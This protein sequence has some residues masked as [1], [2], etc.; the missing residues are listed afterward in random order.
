MKKSIFKKA[1]SLAAA[2]AMTLGFSAAIPAGAE[3]L[4]EAQQFTREMGAGWVLGN[5]LDATA[6]GSSL[7]SETSWGNP[8][9]TKAMIEAVHDAGFETIRIPVSWG[10]HTTG[11]NFEI[12]AEWL[13][14]VKQVVDWAYNDGM[15]VILNIHH[16]NSSAT[17]SRLYYYPDSA[18]KDASLT[19]LTSVWSQ[20][21]EEFQDYDDRLIFET[22]N[23]PRLCGTDYEWWFDP[24]N[25][26]DTVKDSLETINTF[27][28]EIVNT[29]REA[30][31]KN[32]ERYIMCPGYAASLSGITTSYF[33]V[34]EDP[35][36]KVLIAV[37]S[38]APQS[39]C[40]G[41]STDVTS[42]KATLFTDEGREE[43]TSLFETLNN[44]Y[45]SK[46]YG[47]VIGEMGI[48]NKDNNCART[49]WADH[50]FTKSKEYGIPCM[51]WD[52]NAKNGSNKSEN[53]WHF[54]RKTCKWGDP[55]VINA[56][57]DA[58]GVTERS[59]PADDD[60]VVKKPQTITG[61]K[62]YT[63]TYGASAF[64]LDAK[65]TTSGG[66]KLSYASSD[67][68]IVTVSSTG[69]VSIKGA[70][71]ATI[72]VSALEN[73]NYLPAELK[74]T[75]KVNPMSASKA[76]ITAIP[77]QDYTGSAIEPKLTVKL[78]GKVLSLNKDYTVKY[79]NN[80]NPGTATATVTF[81][82]NYTGTVSAQF[83]IVGSAK[84][85]TPVITSYSSS[86]SAVK[87]NWNKVSGADGY[88]VY[89]YNTSTKKWDKACTLNSAD[90]V[91]YRDSSLKAATVYKYKVKAFSKATGSTVWSDA[92]ATYSTLTKPAAVSISKFSK[93]STAVRVYWTK[94]ACTGYKLQQYKGGKWVTVKVIT[95]PSV[96]NYR[97]S[98]LS[99]NTTYKFRVQAYKKSGTLASYSTWSAAKSVT[100]SK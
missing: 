50:F 74:V 8:K 56:I 61:T 44:Q 78:S 10:N 55:D 91:N 14:R 32:T 39:L 41:S 85:A 67:A 3:T 65:N 30:G 12:N 1:L 60:I 66:G 17:A 9:T 21:A 7:S 72:T 73:A 87:I 40:L 63:K 79:T 81:K 88:R 5:S 48:S 54:N 97:L 96:T 52:N 11:D 35:S 38:Y 76:V 100:T 4:T 99:K 93:T 98:G 83:K 27:N 6:G 82:G 25:P 20:V 86:A 24:N 53:H 84:P 80:V 75:V 57:M 94:T 22:L 62:S 28:Q 51:L 2:A 37:H 64:T 89:R 31:G 71:T 69:S 59:I 18:H 23:E 46:G 29:I 43:I 70:G 34:P 95:D 33:K 49:A 13:G 36:N 45:Y 19:F 90:V 15:H 68:S 16:D 42:A 92:T 26:N 58:M 77:D 47:V